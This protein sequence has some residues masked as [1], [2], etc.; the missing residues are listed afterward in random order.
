MPPGQQQNIPPF[1]QRVE[2]TQWWMKYPALT[3]MVFLRRDIGYRFLDP[4]HLLTVTGILAAFSIMVQPAPPRSGPQALL[5]FAILAFLFGIGQRNKRMKELK[6]G[7]VQHSYYI[8]TSIF[9]FRWLPAFCRNDRRMARFFDPIVCFVIGVAVFRA[10]CMLCYWLVFAAV[11]LRCFEDAV[12]RR[13]RNRDLDMLDNLIL[14]GI[15]SNTVEQFEKP[16]AALPQQAA[17]GVPTGLA[18][19]IA[20]HIERRNLK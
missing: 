19:D 17:T 16:P 11:C 1:W 12:H 13:E 3:V 9:D 6:Q 18:P 7:I 4:R 14:S 5:W 8:G 10:S 20:E 2:N 15:H